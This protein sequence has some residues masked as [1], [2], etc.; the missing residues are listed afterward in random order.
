MA[1]KKPRTPEDMEKALA[2][3]NEALEQARKEA[4]EEGH[5]RQGHGG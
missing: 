5:V 4:E 3:A 2:A 1:E